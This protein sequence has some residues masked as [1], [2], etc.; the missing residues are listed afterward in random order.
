V[1]E[2]TA[3]ARQNRTGIATS[4]ELAR[5]MIENAEELSPEGG[6]TE[7]PLEP[8]RAL[9]VQE[10]EP[11][12]SMP[13]PAGLKEMVTSALKALQ[14]EDAA[15][16]LDA[17]GAR[18][19]FERTGTRM[20]EALLT[21]AR[22]LGQEDGG[23]SASELEE[24]RN[25]ELRHFALLVQ[26]IERLGGDP[27]ALTPSADVEAVASTGLLQVATDPRIGMRES[28]RAAHIAELADNDSWEMLIR[29]A[30]A[31]GQTDLVES[32]SD[33]LATEQ[34][35]LAQVRRW[36]SDMTHLSAGVDDSAGVDIGAGIAVQS[37]APM[38]AELA[39]GPAGTAG[40][41]NASAGSGASA[42]AEPT[43]SKAGKPG[44]AGNP[45]R[46][47]KATTRRGRAV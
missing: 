6:A 47:R 24:I 4:P 29:L 1:K 8:I 13:P 33:C 7:L 42:A 45:T 16:L 40:A 32:L 31:L 25:D 2:P 5:E 14:G 3:E 11:V 43:A 28:L 35:H 27:T 21:K 37:P 9:Y 12:G 41:S 17:L 18:L 36:L 44:K 30:A 22:A 10:A 20:Y 26:A 19:G 34:Q 23:P 38:P 15:V 46:P 39:A